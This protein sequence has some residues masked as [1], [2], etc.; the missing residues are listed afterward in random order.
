[1]NSKYVRLSGLRSSA[2]PYA[3]SI[4]VE[5]A[6]TLYFLSYLG[7]TFG[8]AWLGTWS[9]VALI[10]AL[11]VPILT[12]QAAQSF[13][14]FVP[15]IT[16]EQSRR[17][18]V[19]I[20]NAVPQVLV[21]IVVLLSWWTQ[22]EV[23]GALFPG[24]PSV[25][26]LVMLVLYLWSEVQADLIQSEF[27]AQQRIALV[28]VFSIA[29]SITR[30]GWVIGSVE[31]LGFGLEM[32]IISYLLAQL[33]ILSILLF[34]RRKPSEVS[35]VASVHDAP[36]GSLF[37]SNLR[38]VLPLVLISMLGYANSF[39]DRYAIVPQFGLESLATYSVTYG[40][41]GIVVLFYVVYGYSMYP[42]MSHAVAAGRQDEVDYLFTFLLV[43]YLRVLLVAC[44]VWLAFGETILSAV[45]GIEAIELLPLG[46]VQLGIFLSLGCIQIATYVLQLSIPTLR[47]VAP[48]GVSAG[49]TLV[50]LVS[51]QDRFGLVGI[52]FA[53]L[54][55][56]VVLSIWYL[57]TVLS[58]T[59]VI[60]ERVLGFSI[61][62]AVIGVGLITVAHLSFP[63]TVVVGLA[64]VLAAVFTMHDFT[65]GRWSIMK[66]VISI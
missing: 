8:P 1:M 14:K 5:R 50:L 42:K 18:F 16:S 22:N 15:I 33:V 28:G 32:S 64:V 17:R 7:R 41:V 43:G 60:R 34:R 29:R 46:L 66:N 49:L 38:Y 45:F 24:S 47:L 58:F 55:P 3:V 11:L 52:A 44:A 27:R 30:V 65:L 48:V 26:A 19:L 54:I 63:S 21:G 31:L 10:S 51:I 61:M 20:L 35:A 53:N 23:G 36:R 4:V 37:V 39:M 57:R 9:Q 13:I 12:L 6:S 59:S 56:T 62:G 2:G 25:N 40:I